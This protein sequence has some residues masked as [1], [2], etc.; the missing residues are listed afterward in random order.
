M[1]RFLRIAL[2]ALLMSTFALPAAADPDQVLRPKARPANF[3]E[4]IALS[5]LPTDLDNAS[6]FMC[7]AVAVYHEAR[8]ES[9]AGQLAVGSVIVQR[10]ATPGRWGTTI[11]DVIKPVQFSF[12]N[13]AGRFPRID[14]YAA[15]NRARTVAAFILLSG[16]LDELKG[17]DHYHTVDVTPKWSRKMPVV[18]RVGAHIFYADPRSNRAG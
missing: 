4:T 13:E 6:N 5:R 10:A 11:C 17:A 16:P 14:D 7:L 1:T 3:H 15:W 18:H 2:S 9:H 8:G 12:L